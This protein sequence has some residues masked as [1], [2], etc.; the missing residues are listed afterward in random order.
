VGAIAAP[1][2][3]AIVGLIHADS[4]SVD[5]LFV[6]LPLPLMLL[7][8]GIVAGYVHLWRI[9]FIEPIMYRDDIGVMG[10]WKRFLALF[11]SRPFPFL[12]YG[13]YSLVLLSVAVGVVFAFGVGT[14]TIGFF[15]LA[16]PYVGSVVLLPLEV[17]FRALGPEFLAQFGREYAALGAPVTPLAPSATTP[18]SAPTTG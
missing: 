11:V 6:L 14:L 13:V 2:L 12:A 15:L 16:I 8:V 9:S 1:F 18:T 5:D 10:A 7:P 17:T 4:F 3:A